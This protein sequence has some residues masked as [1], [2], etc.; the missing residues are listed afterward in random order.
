MKAGQT[1]KRSLPNVLYV[2]LRT[3]NARRKNSLSQMG[4]DFWVFGEVF[5]GKKNGYFLEVGSADGVT[6]SNTFLLEKRFGWRGICIEANP[7][8]FKELRRARGATCLNLCIDA[9]EG[10]IDFVQKGLYGGIVGDD[11]DNAPEAESEKGAYRVR[12]RTL[13]LSSVLA[14]EQ[15]PHVID[16]LSIDVEGSED[17]IL[18]GFPFQEYVFN[19]ITVERPKQKLREILSRNGYLAVKEIPHHDVFYVHE[20]FYAQYEQNLFSFWGKP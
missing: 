6:F 16:Y 20:S 2:P 17:R 11:T 7:L 5:D 9:V 12:L 4:Q 15:A 19:C 18:S 14:R 10:E 13:P 8:L 3:L 1:L